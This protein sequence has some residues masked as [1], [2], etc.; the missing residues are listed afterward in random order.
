MFP[1]GTIKG[2]VACKLA[3]CESVDCNQNPH[4]SFCFYGIFCLGE[5][6]F[7]QSVRERC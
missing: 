3:K 6:D 7:V 2:G 5:V 4:C 1:N